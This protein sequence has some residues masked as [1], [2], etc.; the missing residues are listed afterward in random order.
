MKMFARFKNIIV[1]AILTA[2]IPSQ[3]GAQGIIV[4]VGSSLNVNSGQLTVPGNVIN[5]GNISVSTLIGAINLTG[6]W[7]N[8]GMLTATTGGTVNL[9]GTSGTQILNNGG[10]NGAF[11]NLT[12][13]A[14]S[15]AQIINNPVTINGNFTNTAGTFD[16]NSLNMTVD[17]NWENTAAFLP[18]TNKVTLGGAN[19]SVQEVLGTTTFYD[20][21]KINTGTATLTFDSTT[22]AL[23][24]FTHSLT[25]EGIASGL[26]T[27]NSNSTNSPPD[28]AFIALVPG[29]A[30][31][32]F[33]VDVFYSNASKGVLLV[34][35][36]AS[37][38]GPP[39]GTNI[40]W[41]FGGIT[42]TWIG[43]TSTDWNNPLNWDQDVVPT[44]VDT[45]IIP[46]PPPSPPNPPT[47]EPVLTT[48]V[49][50]AKLTIQ[51]GATLTLNGNGLTVNAGVGTFVNSGNLILEGTEPVSL[52]QDVNPADQG[53]FT[54]VGNGTASVIP[55][56]SFGAPDYYNLVIN[57]TNIFQ[58][59]TNITT[60]G[61]VT[62]TSGTLDISTHSNTLTVGGALTVGGTS[63]AVLNA[64]NGSI[65]AGSVSIASGDTFTAPGPAGTFTDA[66]NF[67]NNA[68]NYGVPAGNTTGFNNSSGTV[69]FI[70]AATPTLISGNTVFY[71]F[72]STTPGKTINITAGSIQTVNNTFYLQGATGALIN[73]NSTGAQW[74]LDLLAPQTVGGVNVEGSVASQN[75]IC[76][77]C[78]DGGNNVK[79]V[80]ETLS[81]VSPA[82]GTT[83]GQ[84]PT[85][86]GIAPAGSTVYI[87]DISNNLVATTKAD[88]NNNFRV[89]V[90]QDAANT[91]L[92]ITSQL[93]QGP[94]AL[95]PY[96][97]PGLLNPGLSNNIT[98]LNTT[99]SASQVPVITK[100]N[101]NPVVNPTAVQFLTTTTPTIA[102]QGA[103][104]QPVTAQALDANGNLIET[105]PLGNVAG[106]G[107]YLVNWPPGKPL[108]ASSNYISITVGS[109]V[110]ETTSALLQVTLTS[111]FG[112]V[113]NSINNQVIQGAA[114]T[115][116]NATTKQPATGVQ[117]CNETGTCCD[118]SGNCCNSG[119]CTTGNPPGNTFT[120][121]ADGFYSF[122][123]PPGSVLH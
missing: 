20:F 92:A 22:N 122:L 21:S 93:A 75:V 39:A 59:T 77:D 110:N 68:G 50:V 19:G 44:P 29:G 117:S 16:A 101:G 36:A 7:T 25:M 13:S 71:N 106:D 113:F 118:T 123:A 45:V 61:S 107:T 24:T 49:S 12:H 100:L 89:V 111:P 46:T 82:V 48:P 32:I 23:Q 2:F 62:L 116:Y 102:G 9:N 84:T 63:A 4:P 11:Y 34:G 64:A 94:N 53:T 114:V 90:G 96:L 112:Y 115:L 3:A 60:T 72:D 73:F 108:P 119:V 15:T 99:P 18:G 35:R 65:A 51:T 109:S 66:G 5:A 80:F 27:I 47:N 58:T 33:N 37:Q 42:I 85:I 74:N 76:Y 8:S 30:Q 40:N 10:A 103:A 52:T 78:N 121:L 104:G 83:V 14:A 95:T 97:T 91:K 98:V 54:Y 70:S 105:L 87:R 120:T 79:W 26:L 6:N 1:C 81:I 43:G 28:K 57:G 56:K 17:G 86:L 88:I 67:T 38:D 41:A 55:I 31:T 69:T